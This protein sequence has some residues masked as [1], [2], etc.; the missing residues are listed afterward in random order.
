LHVIVGRV[1]KN[2]HHI[3]RHTFFFGRRIINIVRRL[4]PAA[5]HNALKQDVAWCVP[6]NHYVDALV[7]SRSTVPTRQPDLWC[8]KPSKDHTMLAVRRDAI[9]DHVNYKFVRANSRDLRMTAQANL[10]PVSSRIWWRNSSPLAICAS[11]V[12][13][14]STAACVPLPAPGGP[15]KSR[16]Q[17]TPC[18][19]VE[20]PND[21]AD[22]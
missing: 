8:G 1:Y 6:E 2:H 16:S 4:A 15:A 20:R 22:C 17:C 19:V 3:N 10:S 13:A 5:V 18:V 14:S 21:T 12:R 7:I 9:H 11:L